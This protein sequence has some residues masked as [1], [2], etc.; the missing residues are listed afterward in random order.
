M[1]LE[2]FLSEFPDFESGSLD[3]DAKDFEVIIQKDTNLDSDD[4]FKVTKIETNW[5]DKKV[6]IYCEDLN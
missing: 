6:I 5:S 2:D 4:Q 3:E 1:K